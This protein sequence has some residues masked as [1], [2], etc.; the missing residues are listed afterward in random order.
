MTGTWMQVMAQGWVMTTLTDKAVMLGMVNLA[1]GLPMLALTMLGGSVADR[2]DKR[3]ILLLTQVVQIGLAVLVGVLVAR[4]Q[5][6]IWHVLAVAFALGISNSFEMP[7]ASALVPE[8]VEKSEVAV[9]IAIDRAIFH[10]TRLIGP[11]LAG[12]LIAKWGTPSAFY[13]NALSFLA[14]MAAL[15]SIHPRPRGN[16]E[17]EEKRKSGMKEGLRYV[18][19]DQPTLAMI[20]LMATSTLFV[21]PV[22]VVM[23]PLYCRSI[24]GLGADATGLL[25]GISGVGSVAGSIGLMSITRTRRIRWMTG[26]SAGIALGL[27]VLAA[28]KRFDIAAGALIALTLGMS[29]TIGLANTIIQE[30]APDYLRGRVSAVAGLS[31]FGLMPVAGLF[32]TSL[33]DIIGMR[34]ALALGAAAYLGIAMVILLRQLFSESQAAADSRESAA[35][36]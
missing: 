33:S 14:L 22:M 11:A 24:L 9:A 34:R 32:L 4:G 17:E 36:V 35:E 6:E 18:R 26:G 28:A 10:A 25:M 12:Y 30:R 2:F 7:A 21:F 27:A 1:A 31:F 15:L 19:G 20:A 13:A 29:T 16:A 23:M 3:R 8:L 5:I